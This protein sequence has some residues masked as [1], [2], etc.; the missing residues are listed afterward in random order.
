MA[1]TDAYATAKANLRDNVKTLIAVFGGIAGVLLAGTPFSGYGALEPVSPTWLLASA[2]LF[3][4]VVLVGLSLRILLRVLRPDLAY[5]QALHANY[6][7]AA[8]RWFADREI[9]ALRAEFAAHKDELLPV[10]MNSLE[11]LEGKADKAW[12]SYQVSMSDPARK[13]FDD[14]NDALQRINHWSGFVR[15]HRRVSAGI[16]IVFL[17]GLLALVCIGAFAWSVGSHKNKPEDPRVVVI[18]A[19][20]ETE[21]TVDR[22]PS[23]EAV[24]FQTGRW[25]LSAQA[26]ANVAV[27]RDYLRQHPS[28]GLL[29]F[30]YTDTQ[31]GD[32]V[33]QE[34]AGKR[35]AEVSRA[36]TAEGG[37]SPSRIFLSA[38]PKTDLPALT[39][40]KAD[41]ENNRA[42]LLQIIP[43]PPRK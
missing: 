19:A 3:L 21:R 26:L 36:L 29:I 7:P 31:G 10:G 23:I 20:K 42:V 13:I 32:K 39:A 17:M 12:A 30:A 8:K 25:V 38:L 24:H 2:S 6:N 43:L 14:L 15:F 9:K 28:F 4:A 37:I 34:L 1:V 27:A 35:A 18:A 40:S 41:S 33:N 5:S 22:P 16:D 11:E